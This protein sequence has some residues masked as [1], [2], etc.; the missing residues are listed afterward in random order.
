MVGKAESIG[1][2]LGI[3]VDLFVPSRIVA[4]T[5]RRRYRCTQIKAN[6]RFFSSSSDLP[7]KSVSIPM[8]KREELFGQLCERFSRSN[9]AD[10]RSAWDIALDTV[11]EVGG[12]A[13]NAVSMN[14]QTKQLLWARSSMERCWLD[15][16]EAND[17]QRADPFLA[18]FRRGESTF[19]IDAGTLTRSE[20]T[21]DRAFELNHNLALGGYG[22]FLSSAFGD[23]GC[24]ERLMVV[25]CSRYRL[26]EVDALAGIGNVQLINAFIAANIRDARP[27]P[28]SS[29]R[30][31]LRNQ[32]LTPRER[33]I[34]LWLASGLRND[35][36]AYRANI[37][38][39]TVRKHLI[40]IRRKLNARTREQAIAIAV[41]DGWIVP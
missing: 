22:S 26:H 8:E 18:S 5:K 13:L 29:Q 27:E 41:R 39:V 32:V 9:A 28:L 11:T 35:Q 40:S 31:E 14:S 15:E 4:V 6:I 37:A 33:D 21:H 16:Y 30:I 2:W 34:L 23:F 25:F 17:Y 12:S 36:I 24:G 38:E 19:R 10:G 3:I 20:Q 7:Q 1:R